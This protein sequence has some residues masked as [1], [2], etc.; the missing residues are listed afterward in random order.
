[1]L[2][3]EVRFAKDFGEQEF[4]RKKHRNLLEGQR[5]DERMNLL[6]EAEGSGAYETV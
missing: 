5:E 4:W 1:V 6:E 3:G 2:W